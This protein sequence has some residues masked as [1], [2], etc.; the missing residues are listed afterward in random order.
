MIS[1]ST[2]RLL[3]FGPHL[4]LPPVHLWAT[5][6][7]FLAEDS[8]VSGSTEATVNKR[9]VKVEQAPAQRQ[10]FARLKIVAC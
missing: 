3:D 4:A 2:M 5:G 9:T 10:A 7:S 6:S 8:S 1:S